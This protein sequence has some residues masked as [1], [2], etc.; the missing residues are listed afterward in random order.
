MCPES[1]LDCP[2]NKKSILMPHACQK[3]G[4]WILLL[5]PLM[6]GFYLIL[7]YDFRETRLF[8]TVNDNSRFITMVSYI[9]LALSAFFICLSKEKVEDEM[10]AQYRLKAVGVTAY[11]CLILMMVIFLLAAVANVFPKYPIV[12]FQV[13]G[14]IETLLP[15]FAVA[16]YYLLFKGM[17][18]STRKGQ[19]L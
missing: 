4:W 8:T 5:I 15:F 13:K 1:K 18:R 9:V 3:L 17:L 19:G 16:L 7:Y 2:M 6:I 11:V 14:M 10:I 12:L